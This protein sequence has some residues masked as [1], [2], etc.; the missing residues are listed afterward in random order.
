M[1]IGGGMLVFDGDKADDFLTV[2]RAQEKLSPDERRRLAIEAFGNDLDDEEI[3]ALSSKDMAHASGTLFTAIWLVDVIEQIQE[4]KIP[5]LRN[6]DGDELVHCVARYPL[7]KGTRTDEIRALLQ[8]HDGFC[9]IDETSWNWTAMRKP[10]AS[11]AGEQPEPALK[12]E[13]WSEDGALVLGAVR[14]EKRTLV[15]TVNSSER[16]DRGNALLS[17]LLGPRLGRPS[18]EVETVEQIMARDDGAE[19]EQVDL[20]DDEMRAVVHNQMDRHYRGVLDEPVGTLGG[21][22]PRA[23]V[24][25]RDGRVKVVEWLKLLEN[26][27]AKAGDGNSAMASYSFGWMWEELGLDDLRR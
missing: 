9:R 23:A 13:T 25:T 20:S 17:G 18:I 10:A 2:W 11:H 21:L 6:G 5:D 22:T 19:I 24:K 27:T 12:L 7:S 26:R 1:Q 14:L 3:A 4:T 15:L 8:A 16:C